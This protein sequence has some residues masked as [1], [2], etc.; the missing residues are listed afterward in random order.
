[1]KIRFT[2]HAPRLSD[3]DSHRA[4]AAGLPNLPQRL[5]DRHR[6]RVLRPGEAPVA[7]G[8]ASPGSTIYRYDRVLLCHRLLA[9][10]ALMTDVDNAL[11]EIGVRLDHDAIARTDACRPHPVALRLT[12][13]AAPGTVDA[14]AA[15]QTLHGA[16]SAGRCATEIT[17]RVRLD[18]LMVGSAL[19]GVGMYGTG[20]DGGG[21][22]NGSGP[23][24]EQST[25]SSGY[26]NRMPVEV[27]APMPPRRERGALPGNRRPVIAV[28]DTGIVDGHP[29]FDVSDRACAR[30][31]FV[32]VDEELQDILEAIADPQS[33]VLH[34]TRDDP[35]VPGSLLGDLASHYGH[36]T[37]IA[38]IIRQLAPDAQVRSIRVMHNDGLVYEN[39]CVT[40]LT[41]IAD[42]VERARDGDPTAEPVD[43]VSLSFGY[44]DETPGD[45]PEGGLAAV[46]RRLTGLGVPVVCAA[47]N[48]ASDRPFYPAAF[49][50]TPGDGPPSA[51]VLS[52]GALNPNGTVA[53]FSN[54][55]P[56]VACY[57]TGAGLVSTVPYGVDGA[58]GPAREVVGAG[59]PRESL[60]PDDF[61]TGFA[62]W[63]GTSFAAPVVAARIAA[64]M[65]DS[66]L[67][68]GRHDLDAAAHRVRD[69]IKTISG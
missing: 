58:T 29:A 50:A 5:L 6:A 35:G 32:V 23:Y 47:G 10:D 52:V 16:V 55:G 37:F 38:G 1:M 56:W 66:G 48:F 27:I 12:D 59:D 36:G 54:A 3:T 9:D 24:V 61:A 2:D 21:W 44:A 42:E 19:T 40:A 17:G 57:A 39:E 69:A 46:I 65:L 13:E 67:S 20:D 60:D 34:G 30:D 14:W 53:M 31:T 64:A 62:V 18:H 4:H 41:T 45:V 11:G 43:I 8:M 63:S 15:L 7:A 25:L 28:L 22:P 33:P 51:P 68:L 26:L 49:A